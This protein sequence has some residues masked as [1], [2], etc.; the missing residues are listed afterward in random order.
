MHFL[1]F[2]YQEE[3]RLNQIKVENSQ[4]KANSQQLKWMDLTA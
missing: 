2:K 4:F 3:R 1:Q